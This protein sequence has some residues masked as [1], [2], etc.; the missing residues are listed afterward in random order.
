[1][2]QIPLLVLCKVY[3]PMQGHFLVLAE[4]FLYLRRELKLTASMKKKLK[5]TGIV[6]VI[7]DHRSA[8]NHVFILSGMDIA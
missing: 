6:S 8:L 5:L 4:F 1:M 3:C 7:K 2:V